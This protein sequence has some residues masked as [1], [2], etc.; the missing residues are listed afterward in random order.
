ML[1]T[2]KGEIEGLRSEHID[3]ASD[4]TKALNDAIVFFRRLDKSKQY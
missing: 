4:V 3:Y 2:S 1:S